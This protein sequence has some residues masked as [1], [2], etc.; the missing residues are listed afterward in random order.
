[1]YFFNQIF[2]FGM[3]KT[4]SCEFLNVFNFFEHSEIK[5]I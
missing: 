2:P 3:I 1:M 4:N 5:K